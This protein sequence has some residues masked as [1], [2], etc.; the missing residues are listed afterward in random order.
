MKKTLS[1]VWPVLLCL[2]L[3]GLASLLQTDSLQTWYPT[4]RKSALTPPNIA[5]PIAWGIL[6][7]LIGLSA[8]FVLNSTHPGRRRAMGIWFVQLGLNFLWSLLFFTARQ[9][10]LGFLDLLALDIAIVLYLSHSAP[11]SR[12]AAGLF[13]PYL[14]WALFATYLNA[15]IWAVNGAGW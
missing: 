10:L 2:A 8:G 14:C 15:Y 9:P 13:V 4:L 1:F 3:G 5:F 12:W 7:V 11:V 6:Y